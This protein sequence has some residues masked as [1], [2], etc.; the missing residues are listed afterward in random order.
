MVQLNYKASNIAKAEK[1][2][3]M[4]FFDA[5][6][7]LQDKPSISSLLFLFIAGGG[8]TEEFDEVA[9]TGI[10]EIMMAIMEGVSDAG[11]LGTTVD[12]KT[13]KAEMEKAM[14]EAMAALEN[15]GETENA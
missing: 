1:E 10:P 11:F 6:S 3:G 8:T 2:Q 12:S 9:K 15:S 5:F 14:K 4:S 13:L 7:S